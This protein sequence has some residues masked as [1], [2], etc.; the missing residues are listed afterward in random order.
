[1]PELKTQYPFIE[2]NG[3]ENRNLIKH[4]AEDENGVRYYIIQKETGVKYEETVDV[5]PC[6]FTYLVTEEPVKKEEDDEQSEE[7]QGE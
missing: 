6:R 7:K 4:Y 5:Y 1:M 3:I 2:D